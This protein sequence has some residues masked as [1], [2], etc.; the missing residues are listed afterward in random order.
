MIKCIK[1]GKKAEFDFSSGGQRTAYCVDCYKK[2]MDTKQAD[3]E[4][5]GM[6]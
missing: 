1:C 6:D 3:E 2:E 4:D 5:N